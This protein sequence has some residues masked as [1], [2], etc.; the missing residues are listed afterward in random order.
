M[1]EWS[2]EHH[3][4]LFDRYR[5]TAQHD[6][7]A[8]RYK[9]SL[10]TYADALTELEQAK[11]DPSQLSDFKAEVAGA[12][13][14]CGKPAE[15]LKLYNE[16]AV[17]DSK[18]V[19]QN[20]ELSASALCGIGF[21][22]LKMGEYRKAARAFADAQERYKSDVESA[23]RHSFPVDL[24]QSCCAWG[25]YF[26][27]SEGTKFDRWYEKQPPRKKGPFF[28]SACLASRLLL[29]KSLVPSIAIK[30]AGTDGDTT[31]DV[32]QPDDSSI[33][34]GSSS[35]SR[36]DDKI[37]RE[38]QRK[39]ETFV[40][41]GQRAEKAQDNA[42]A[43]RYYKSAISVLRK[44][45]DK[46]IRLYRSVQYLGFLY[47]TSGRREESYPLL[48]ETVEIQRQRFGKDD[49][50]VV[51]PLSRFGVT[52]LKLGKLEEAE[53]ILNESLSL[54]IR[55]F[56][57]KHY[58][59]S[60]IYLNLA[61]LRTAQHRFADAQELAEKANTILSKGEKRDTIRLNRARLLVANALEHQQKLDLAL[62][63]TVEGGS[64]LTDLDPF[65]K[66]YTYTQLADLERKL[67]NKDASIAALNKANRTYLFI[68]NH[69]T[70]KIFDSD[71]DQAVAKMR[72]LKESN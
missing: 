68:T 44:A 30:Q 61:Y 69:D 24:C 13:L 21:C 54:S 5:L 25:L 43:E 40:R 36:L 2:R 29:E 66:L 70:V 31:P 28:E 4:R 27:D 62:K 38:T 12:N 46:G 23:S 16:P 58:M 42:K 9:R 48:L 35:V 50:A 72:S 47:A 22:Y 11:V 10:S 57:E 1:S 52:C 63:W 33:E 49:R 19:S 71:F 34:D 41:G 20:V 6:L 65:G 39:W 51:G 18:S 53:R 56:G 15:A 8:G 64:V 7:I 14:L 45:G 26:A 3:L 55:Y 37:D 59:T 17:I 67:G 32:V 60:I